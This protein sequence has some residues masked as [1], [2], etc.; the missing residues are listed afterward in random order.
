MQYVSESFD[1]APAV[2]S[3]LLAW[4][5]VRVEQY[6]LEAG[7]LAAHY[8]KHHLLL[9]YQVAG[10]FVLHRPSAAHDRAAAYRTGD[11][12]LYPGGEY[13][14]VSWTAP[15]DNIYLMV[16]DQYLEG[17]VHQGSDLTRFALR[18]R[19]RFQDPF[20]GQLGQQ[21]LAAA[22][23][24]HA[25]GLLYVE[26][27]TNA[28]CHQLIEHHATYERR[29][30]AH[31]RLGG[32]V[33][34]RIDA[35]LEAHA[36]APITLEALAALANLSVFHFAHLFKSTTGVAPYQ[37]VLR[38]K[39]QRARQLLRRGHSSVADISAAL[40]FASP[41]SFSAAFKRAVGCSPQQFQ[42]GLN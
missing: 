40:G 1:V 37:H 18:E 39:F 32:A 34:A 15:S 22:G 35:Y 17:L 33:L 25:L 3:E 9:L 29:G 13:D 19:P 16:D 20:L 11:L 10:S 14:T 24:Q 7:E 5:G 6:H 23:S 41:A 2:S 21:L 8:H 26:S 27:L 36:D 4:Q 12:G 28:L 30:T 31:N 42:R 38:W